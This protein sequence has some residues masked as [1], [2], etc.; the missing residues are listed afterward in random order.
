MQVQLT[1]HPAA[2]GYDQFAARFHL[3]GIDPAATNA[4]VKEA[5]TIACG[6]PAAPS[7]LL[8]EARNG[9]LD[10]ARRL[11]CELAYPL[12]STGGQV[13]AFYSG[14]SAITPTSELLAAATTWPPL[15]KANFLACLAARQ[16]ADGNLLTALV[17]AHAAI[18][19]T[20]IFE[21]LRKY[22]SRSG[23]AM[24]SLVEIRQALQAPHPAFRS[25]HSR[26]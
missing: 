6:Q 24:P 21:A 23:L 12:D 7:R 17:E 19:A 8:T 1:S 13:E 25:R 2:S 18:E 26:L 11:L 10:P 3:L 16:P 22:R 4:Q 9:I 20:T 14:L 5:F 15:S